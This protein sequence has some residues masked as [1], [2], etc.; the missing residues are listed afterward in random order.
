M[1]LMKS[2]MGLTMVTPL[3]GETSVLKVNH[4]KFCIRTSL[5]SYWLVRGVRNSPLL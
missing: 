2:T 1:Q 3:G 5:S 4:T